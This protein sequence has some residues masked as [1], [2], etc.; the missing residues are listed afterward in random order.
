M[1]ISVPCEALYHTAALCAHVPPDPRDRIAYPVSVPR[2][3]EYHA[4]S[5]H[6]EAQLCARTCLLM[7]RDRIAPYPVSV[8]CVP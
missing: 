5:V 6:E 2:D 1:P 8:P 3:T 4:S 7:S